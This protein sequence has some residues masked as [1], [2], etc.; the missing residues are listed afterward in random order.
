MNRLNKNIIAIFIVLSYSLYG[1]YGD[2]G[3]I[4]L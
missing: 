4:V 2:G 3:G 1:F